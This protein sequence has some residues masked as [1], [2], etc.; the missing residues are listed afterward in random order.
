MRPALLSLFSD[1]AALGELSLRAGA[2]QT[3][4]LSAVAAGRKT[5]APAGSSWPGAPAR[6]G[7]T[8]TGS[9]PRWRRRGWAT[10][11]RS[12]SRARRRSRSAATRPCCRASSRGWE[13]S[14]GRGRM[15]GVA[16][17]GHPARAHQRAGRL[18]AR[19]ALG[20][21]LP[22]RQTGK[23]ADGGVLTG[24]HKTTVSLTSSRCRCRSRDRNDDGR[25]RRRSGRPAGG[26]HT[27]P[28]RAARA[29]SA[30]AAVLTASTAWRH[31]SGAW[32]RV[33]SL[34]ILA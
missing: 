2:P 1:A 5:E 22:P 15:E 31:V 13:H 27:P 16:S 8:T 32:R 12:G 26:A 19:L 17:D 18:P 10:G 30:A 23:S 6:P 21:R 24:A 11:R 3:G 28:R 7:S 4:E 29:R 33:S 25:H 34:P 20:H 14:H 9:R